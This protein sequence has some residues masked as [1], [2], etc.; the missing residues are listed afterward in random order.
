MN[1]FTVQQQTLSE[2]VK[3]AAK[4]GPANPVALGQQVS[5]RTKIQG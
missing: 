3:I 2:S 1:Y 5:V 4:S